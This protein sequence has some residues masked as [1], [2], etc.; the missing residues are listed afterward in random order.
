MAWKEF[1]SADIVCVMYGGGGSTDLKFACYFEKQIVVNSGE[2]LWYKSPLMDNS[3]LGAADETLFLY[4]A[5]AVVWWV[6]L[7]PS[8]PSQQRYQRWERLSVVS[9]FQ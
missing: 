1:N 4:L 9:T 2:G 6:L 5:E 3:Q 7:L 8:Q